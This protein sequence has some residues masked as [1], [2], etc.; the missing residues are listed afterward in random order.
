VLY[1]KRGNICPAVP[2]SFARQENTKLRTSNLKFCPLLC[3]RYLGKTTTMEKE[4][5]LQGN[6]KRRERDLG[7]STAGI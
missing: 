5:L 2:L 7:N 4:S 6:R 3:L 1:S